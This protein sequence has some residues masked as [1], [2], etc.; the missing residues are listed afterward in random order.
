M[1]QKYLISHAREGV[2]AA[3]GQGSCHLCHLPGGGLN[4]ADLEIKVERILLL[5]ALREG[6]RI[7]HHVRKRVVSGGR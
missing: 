7:E 2:S 1:L 3:V 4:G 6:A 5:S